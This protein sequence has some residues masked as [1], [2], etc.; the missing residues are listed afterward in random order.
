MTQKRALLI[1]VLGKEAK[2]GDYIRCLNLAEVRSEGIYRLRVLEVVMW[3][4][5]CNISE[6]VLLV[7]DKRLSDGQCLRN[8]ME[9]KGRKEGRTQKSALLFLVPC[10]GTPGK[11]L[12]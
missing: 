4:L 5:H 12:I 3:G 6:S 10:P 2:D 1:D 7:V 11:W 8:R 9:E